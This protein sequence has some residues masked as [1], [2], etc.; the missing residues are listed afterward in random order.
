MKAGFLV[1]GWN[2]PDGNPLLRGR[3]VADMGGDFDAPTDKE[4]Q[5]LMFVVKREFFRLR[6]KR[7][8]Q[9]S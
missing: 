8:K 3:V 5:L 2:T 7:K 1:V 4:M 9:S 6:S